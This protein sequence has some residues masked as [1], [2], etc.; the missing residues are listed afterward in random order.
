MP[1]LG[2]LQDKRVGNNSRKR[3]LQAAN[4][5]SI[6]AKKARLIVDENVNPNILPTP[7][8]PSTA[9]ENPNIYKTPSPSHLVCLNCS[10]TNVLDTELLNRD[11]IPVEECGIGRR[12][13]TYDSD[14]KAIA[15]LGEKELLRMLIYLLNVYRWC[16]S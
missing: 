6:A 1:K 8:T 3:K 5:A 2:S 4:L 9:I 15:K 13:L 14:Y 16:Q 10:S 12:T 11:L 7:S